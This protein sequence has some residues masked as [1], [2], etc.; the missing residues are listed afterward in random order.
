ME[1][2][3]TRQVK[4][5]KLKLEDSD[6]PSLLNNGSRAILLALIQIEV[7]GA[8]PNDKTIKALN[9]LLTWVDDHNNDEVRRVVTK[10]FID[11]GGIPLLLMFTNKNIDKV[12]CVELS[13]DLLSTI[14]DPGNNHDQYRRDLNIRVA[15]IIIERKG[16]QTMILANEKYFK[17][18]DASSFAALNYIW[19]VLSS[20]CYHKT[21]VD[22]INKD[23]KISIITSCEVIMN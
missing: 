15:R 14:L 16:V 18:N 12:E 10:E 11:I 19:K 23:Q 3:T 9:D 7:A 2:N 13:A 8:Y 21:S 4:R 5:Q 22:I 1:S 20:I 17:D 6:H